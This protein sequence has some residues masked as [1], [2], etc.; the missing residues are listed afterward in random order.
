VLNSTIAF[1]KL[2]NGRILS[3]LSGVCQQK[4]K[5]VFAERSLF[6]KVKEY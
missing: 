3:K 6:T 4:N 1:V 5:P 2:D